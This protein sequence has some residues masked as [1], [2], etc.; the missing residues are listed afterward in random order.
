MIKIIRKNKQADNFTLVLEDSEKEIIGKLLFDQLIE[1]DVTITEIKNSFGFIKIPHD[2]LTKIEKSILKMGKDIHLTHRIIKGYDKKS[3]NV[4]QSAV[5]YNALGIINFFKGE[6]ENALK[7]FNKALE[8]SNVY[9][10]AAINLCIAANTRASQFDSE[11]VML[12]KVI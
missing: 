10:N 4:S 12:K 8:Y 3:H 7:Y 11:H 9:E 1:G 2:L 5:N 6:L